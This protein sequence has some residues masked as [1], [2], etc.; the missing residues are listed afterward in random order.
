MGCS[1]KRSEN[2]LFEILK[3]NEFHEDNIYYS[4]NQNCILK[5]LFMF[6]SKTGLKHG[7]PD[8]I[9]FDNDVLIIFECKSNCLH[10]AIKDLKH[11]FDSVNTNKY[12]LFGVAFVSKNLYIIYDEKF[13][14]LKNKIICLDTFNLKKNNK[15]INM[16]QEIHKINNYIRDNTKISDDDKGFFIAIILISIHKISFKYLFEKYKSKEY[17]YDLLLDNLKDFNIDINVFSSLRNDANNIHLYNL[18][19]M[20]YN[21]YN[22]EPNIDLL[23]EFYNEFVKY[24]NS[25]GKK[26][27]IVLTPPHIVKLMCEMLDINKD[28]IVLDLCTGTG[29]FLLESHKY[30]PKKIIGCE[31]QNKLYALLKCNM[32]LHNINNSELY[33]GNCFDYEFK[34]TKSLINPP[35]GNKNDTELDF[36]LKQ[37]DSVEENS[38]IIAIIPSSKLSNKSMNNKRN[39][40]I[41]KAKLMTI[42]NCRDTLFYPNAN[43]RCSIILLKKSSEGHTENDLYNIINYENDGFESIKQYGLIKNDSFEKKYIELLN[44]LN[45]NKTR[46]LRINQEWNEESDMNDIYLSLSNIRLYKLEI[47]YLES[48]NEIIRNDKII[49][50]NESNHYNLL[51]LFDISISPNIQLKNLSE[52]GDYNVISSSSINNSIHKTKKSKTKDF[53][54]NCLTL[55]KNGSVGYCFYQTD[56]FV[57][58]SDVIVLKYKINISEN[59]YIYLSLLLTKICTTKFSYSYKITND[60]LKELKLILPTINNIIDYETI[61]DLL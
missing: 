9:Y 10:S 29:S 11:Y 40:I 55:N 34:A 25:D 54:G 17:I 3:E 36:I 1:E 53:E 56:P 61:D 45:F 19:N 41:K 8:R 2:E 18:I 31:Y 16:K 22:K 59:I 39:E 21:I 43:V 4:P 60:R 51:D 47:E 27:G 30:N 15:P 33:K 42:I 50:F 49:S 32:I 38:L 24:N 23:N 26:L 57:K 28:D 46:S 6:S 35:Y 14:E 52:E 48:K 5:S 58:T 37:I 44:S 13:N 12:K 20:I 7:I